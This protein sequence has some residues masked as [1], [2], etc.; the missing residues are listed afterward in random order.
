MAGSAIRQDRTETVRSDGTAI[1]L[2]A[3]SS[4]SV[5]RYKRSGGYYPLQTVLYLR[6]RP[7]EKNTACQ[8]R[9]FGSVRPPRTRCVDASGASGDRE[10]RIKEIAGNGTNE[11]RGLKIIDLPL[12][13]P[14][15]L[16]FITINSL[17]LYFE[18]NHCCI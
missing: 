12:R 8:I 2:T 10:I 16:S 7:S 15:I 14:L 11:I 17:D 5:D 13:Q 6:T 3:D 4:E 18:F 1:V 9:A